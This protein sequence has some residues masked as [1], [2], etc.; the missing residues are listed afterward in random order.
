MPVRLLDGRRISED[1]L[2]RVAKRVQA[3]VAA[4]LRA[5]GLAVVMV[6][7]DPASEVYVRN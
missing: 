2:A 6:G 1:V 7:S 5:P 4:G 3:R